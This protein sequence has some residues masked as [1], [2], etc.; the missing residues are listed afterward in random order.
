[1][2]VIRGQ[3]RNLMAVDMETYGVYGAAIYGPDP[4][5]TYFSIKGV[6]DFGENDKSDK[7]QPYAAYT[8]AQALRALIERSHAVLFRM[9]GRI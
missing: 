5:P 8:S 2:D 3:H 9:A 6:S 1:M 7:W 4:R